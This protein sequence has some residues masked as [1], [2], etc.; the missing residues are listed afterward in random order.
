MSYKHHS[1]WRWETHLD[2]NRRIHR[3]LM[4]FQSPYSPHTVQWWHPR[5]PLQHRRSHAT[6]LVASLPMLA[7][8][9]D[10]PPSGSRQLPS[11]LG[12]GKIG[13]RSMLSITTGRN[14]T[15]FANSLAWVMMSHDESWWVMMS[16]AIQIILIP[17]QDAFMVILCTSCLQSWSFQGLQHI[18]FTGAV[19]VCDAWARPKVGFKS[20]NQAPH[21]C[22]T[23]LVYKSS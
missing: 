15:T 11:P 3:I 19:H 21:L 6:P 16:Y 18:L 13:K 8:A 1:C 5:H 10:V 4:D 22:Q 7:A 9:E 2:G 20:W 12:I 14:G 17:F 23:W